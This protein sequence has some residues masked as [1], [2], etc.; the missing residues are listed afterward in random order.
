MSTGEEKQTLV[1]KRRML[2]KWKSLGTKLSLATTQTTGVM[3][4][5]GQQRG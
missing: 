2:V 5:I 3:T 4:M 1:K